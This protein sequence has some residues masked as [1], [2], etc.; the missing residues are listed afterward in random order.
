MKRHHQFTT[1]LQ[2]ITSHR[3]IAASINANTPWELGVII[4]LR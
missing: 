4:A 1:A 2:T 3:H